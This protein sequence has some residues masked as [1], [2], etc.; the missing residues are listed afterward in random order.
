MKPVHALRDLKWW[1]RTTFKQ[2]FEGPEYADCPDCSGQVY[3]YHHGSSPFLI[4]YQCRECSWSNSSPQWL[5]STVFICDFN[6][7]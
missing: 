6:T 3:H 2:W 1:Y 7:I 4:K 5:H